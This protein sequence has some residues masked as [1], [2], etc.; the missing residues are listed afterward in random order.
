MVDIVGGLCCP[1]SLGR[2][3]SILDIILGTLK[4]A[5]LQINW[6]MRNGQEWL[7]SRSSRFGFTVVIIT[8]ESYSGFELDFW[9]SKGGRDKWT[10]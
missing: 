8:K 7:P 4:F 10:R 3:I 6:K 5:I 2:F 1:I 9:G